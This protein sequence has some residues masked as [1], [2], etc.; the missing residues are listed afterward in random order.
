MEE[1]KEDGT[2]S[3]NMEDIQSLGEVS[4][5]LGRVMLMDFIS[6]SSH[7]ILGIV[8][9]NV[10]F[11]RSWTGESSTQG[12]CENFKAGKGIT[13]DRPIQTCN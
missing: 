7:E 8:I 12:H 1:E 13:T 6:H 10:T 4:S 2:C 5:Q 11:P 9:P 3:K